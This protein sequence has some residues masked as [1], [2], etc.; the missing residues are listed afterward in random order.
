MR[1]R[2][3]RVTTY[4]RVLRRNRPK[5]SKSSRRKCKRTVSQIKTVPTCN[6]LYEKC[7]ALKI[8][9]DS[10]SVRVFRLYDQ[11]SYVMLHKLW[12][13][14]KDVEP[15]STTIKKSVN[16]SDRLLEDKQNIEHYALKIIT[17]TESETV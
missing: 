13:T 16:T 3:G 6:V 14:C 2:S 1:L 5:V 4:P 10:E 8:I 11:V 12:K 7:Y 15:P 17:D 9:T